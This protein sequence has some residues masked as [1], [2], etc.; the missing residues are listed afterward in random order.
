MY[1]TVFKKQMPKPLNILK[2]I[3][4]KNWEQIK[5][6]SSLHTEYNS[7]QNRLQ[8]LCLCFHP[9]ILSVAIKSCPLERKL[10]HILTLCSAYRDTGENIINH[11][12]HTRFN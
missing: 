7:F 6:L 5:K 10:V 4:H 9:K 1:F 2:I 12:S 3:A 11:N 8:L